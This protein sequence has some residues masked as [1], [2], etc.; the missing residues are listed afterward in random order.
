[1]SEESMEELQ[2]RLEREN[3]EY[4]RLKK[5]HRELDLKL[6]QLEEKRYLTPEEEMEV[7]KMKKEKLRLKD[8]M[9]EM[10]RAYQKKGA[11]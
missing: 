5:S 9:T 3:E 4:A 1:M 11:T 8:H 10:L 2:K 7:K 6:Q